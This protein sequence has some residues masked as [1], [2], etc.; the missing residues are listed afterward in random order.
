[1]RLDREI[2]RSYKLAELTS[3][4]MSMFIIFYDFQYKK[5]ITTHTFSYN[6]ALILKYIK[7]ILLFKCR[8]FLYS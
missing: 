3:R 1:M 5:A 8:F 7:N 6:F 4:I 2:G